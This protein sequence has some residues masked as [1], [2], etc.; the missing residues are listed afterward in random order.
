MKKIKISRGFSL[1]EALISLALVSFLILGT[2]QLIL[3]ALWVKKGVEDRFEVMARAAQK[4]ETL[5]AVPFESPELNEGDYSETSPD[6]NTG[7]KISC[8][9]H[10]RELSP[11][12]KRIEMDVHPVNHQ[13][14]RISLGLLISRE[15][16][17]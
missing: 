15:L 17:F 14:K 8:K 7:Q 11:S 9:W 2:G 1:I 10:V 16:E 6:R 13:E 4:L 5:K 12:L 3:H